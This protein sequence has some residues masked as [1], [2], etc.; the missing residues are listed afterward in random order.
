MS[1]NFTQNDYNSDMGF[2][3]KIW[4]PLQWVFL[5]M[6]SF[7]Y[8]VNPTEDIKKHYHEYIMALG[9]T[10]PCKSCRYNLS[11]NL[12]KAH[13][14]KDKLKNREEFSRFIYDLHNVVNV[15][16]GKDIYETYN[17]VRDKYEIFRARCVNDVPLIPILE[18]GCTKPANDIYS[19]S[20]VNV[21]PLKLDRNTF[22]IDKKCIPKQPKNGS[23]QSSKVKPPIVKNGNTKKQGGSNSITLPE[24][25]ISDYY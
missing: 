6:I 21:V 10:L 3:T 4:G 22:V 2:N 9:N 16:L 13:Y 24:S 5:H 18:R 11:S 17:E 1:V 25:I 14:G 12:K 7:N 8:P 19:Q 15:M 23:K 20:V